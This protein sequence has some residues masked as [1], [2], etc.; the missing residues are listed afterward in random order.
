VLPADSSSEQA[1]PRAHKKEL[2]L[3]DDMTPARLERL[4]SEAARIGRARNA[5]AEIRRV[6]LAY[7]TEVLQ[8]TVTLDTKVPAPRWQHYLPLD[9]PALEAELARWIERLTDF[10]MERLEPSPSY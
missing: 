2:S 3:T 8:V 1:P 4:A 10:L 5:L 6:T 9:T 7:G